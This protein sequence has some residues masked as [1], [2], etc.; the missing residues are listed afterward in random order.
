M[1]DL[2]G[3]LE[4]KLAEGEPFD[5]R[6]GCNILRAENRHI[7]ALFYLADKIRRKYFENDLA[8]C[9]IVNAKSGSC[10][11]DCSFCSQSVHHNTKIEQYDLLTND[12]LREHYNQVDDLP[13]AHF[14][15][16]TSGPQLSAGEVR[17]ISEFIA[18]LDGAASFCASLGELSSE[19]LEQLQRSG[20]ERYHHNLETAPSFFSEI[21][22]THEYQS[23]V[24][25]IRRAKQLGLEVCSG[26]IIGLG[27]T[28]EQRVEL[29]LT[30]RE[31]E[32]DS[33]PLNFLVPIAGT[34]TENHQP[35][36]PLEILKT[37]SMFRLL[38]PTREIKICAGRNHLRDLQ[39]MLFFAGATGIMIG[40]LLTVAGRSVEKDLQMLKDLGFSGG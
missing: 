34:S 40:D 8:L 14:G 36:E 2:I 25:T 23:R 9:S 10:S 4:K 21:C 7:P 11:Q 32:V 15:I 27:E 1:S 29:A 19:Q 24:Q 26:G 13:L 33:I 22:T 5:R 18:P 37:T 30:L 39:S 16:V 31:L 28:L 3:Q 12:R 38:N 6:D 35:L 17:K 20:L